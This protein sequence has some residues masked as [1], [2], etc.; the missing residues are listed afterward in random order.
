M[1][2]EIVGAC[3]ISPIR[4]D[5]T[6][7]TFEIN[8]G[9]RRKESSTHENALPIRLYNLHIY[10]IIFIQESFNDMFSVNTG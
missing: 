10:I 8:T 4:Y 1:I 9:K 6:S 7:T 5:I 3:K 2:L